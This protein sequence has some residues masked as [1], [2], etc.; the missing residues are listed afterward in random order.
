[1]VGDPII[2]IRLRLSEKNCALQ[3]AFW[4][5]GWYTDFTNNN[6]TSQH[7]KLD[8]YLRREM[9][10]SVREANDE[11]ISLFDHSHNHDMILWKG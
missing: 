10:K 1:M 2:T 7:E 8:S 4:N 9:T 11:A 3:F 6:P 5:W